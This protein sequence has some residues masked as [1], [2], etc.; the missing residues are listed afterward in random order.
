MFY[1]ICA[2]IWIV[3]SI[4]FFKK[5]LVLFFFLKSERQGQKLMPDNDFMGAAHNVFQTVVGNNISVTTTN[6]LSEEDF[7]I[8]YGTNDNMEMEDGGLSDDV[9]TQEIGS[10]IGFKEMQEMVAVV[11]DDK[12]L[13]D[14][15]NKTL[16]EA[17]RT[18]KQIEDT[19]FF[20]QVIRIKED[21]S[22]RI[23]YILNTINN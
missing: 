17:K 2:I 10:I 4:L 7:E 13:T 1:V 9:P 19:D 8:E 23:D 14:I 16:K 5:E 18:I 3:V 21:I 20:A 11:E 12:P 6:I 15:D 22:K